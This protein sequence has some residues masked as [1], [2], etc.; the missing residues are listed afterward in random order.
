MSNKSDLNIDFKD[1]ISVGSIYEINKD[2]VERFGGAGVG[3][4][5]KNLAE[6]AISG[7]YQEVFGKILYPQIEDKIAHLVFSIIKNHI[8][9]DGNKRTGAFILNYLIYKY[10][11][12][13]ESLDIKDIVLKVAK[14]EIGEKELSNILKKE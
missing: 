4:K 11:L 12:K 10:N 8:F 14:S 7:C 9:I 1:I 5:D 3:F 6:S 13:L 2:L